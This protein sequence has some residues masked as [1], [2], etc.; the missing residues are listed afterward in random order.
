MNITPA[1]S[2][3]KEAEDRFDPIPVVYMPRKPNPNGLLA[4]GLAT[5][6]AKTRLPFIVDFEPYLAPCEELGSREALKRIVSSQR[7]RRKFFPQVSSVFIFA[8]RGLLDN[9]T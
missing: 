5:K 2:P 7:P 4:Y 6:S 3:K 8:F 1:Q 9:G